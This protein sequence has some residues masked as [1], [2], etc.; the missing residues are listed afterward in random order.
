MHVVFINFNK[1]SAAFPER[2]SCT[3]LNI[4]LIK[5]IA[6]IIITVVG[7]FSPGSA[8]M[9]SIYAEMIAKKIN[10]HVNG[11]IKASTNLFINDSFLCFVILLLPYK[12]RFSSIC[13]LDN[14]FL[15]LS[16]CASTKFSSCIAEI[17]RRFLTLSFFTML[18]FRSCVIFIFLFLNIILPPFLMFVLVVLQFLVY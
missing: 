12:L 13:S 8:R 15:L 4:P 14:P 17:I 7:F 18:S 5:I 10:I 11:F 2:V 16:M 3:N 1:L 6:V 9:I